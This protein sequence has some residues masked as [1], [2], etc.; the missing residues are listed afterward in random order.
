MLKKTSTFLL[1]KGFFNWAS[2]L[3]AVFLGAAGLD[4]LLVRFGVDTKAILSTD[5]GHFVL[6]C[7]SLSLIAEVW[8]LATSKPPPPP[9]IERVPS[10]EFGASVLMYINYLKSV[11]KDHTVVELRNKL[12]HLFHL[13]GLNAAREQI[14]KIALE[15]TVVIDDRISRAEILID[16]LGWALHLQ[17][18]MQEA[19][20]NIQ[21]AIDLLVVQECVLPEA[22][23]RQHL[24]IAKAHRH[25]A[26][27]AVDAGDQER[28]L[29]EC[30]KTIK[31]IRQKNEVFSL[32]E[33]Q[34]TCDDAQIYHARAY[35]IA[36][37]LGIERQGVIKPSE[38]SEADKAQEALQY[39]THAVALFSG[40]ND[41]EREAKALVLVERLQY[42]LQN[43]I[44]A[45][46]A[47]AQRDAVLAK[48]GIDGGIASISLSGITNK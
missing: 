14:G 27:L 12:T 18:R 34:I 1:G 7:L 29:N 28:H 21:K 17:N 13:L 35:L 48:S 4:Q 30:A 11:G 10:Y 3:V 31:R 2:R 47:K 6:A 16:D 22:K 46:E 5:L 19:R 41:L 8:I 15:A 38:K 26:F 37:N 20:A 40:I 42:A 39:I 43:E 24:A 45:I 33:R 32:F 23:L 9:D 44:E 36:R 25:L